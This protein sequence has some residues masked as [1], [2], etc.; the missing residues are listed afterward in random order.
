MSDCGSNVSIFWFN[1]TSN[2]VGRRTDNCLLYWFAK[3]E[4]LTANGGEILL[5]VAIMWTVWVNFDEC[6]TVQ[7][8]LTFN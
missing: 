4:N 7:S 1:L 6:I 8:I 3:K 5:S 2:I